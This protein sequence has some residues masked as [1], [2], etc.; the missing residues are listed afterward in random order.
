MK[1][2][3]LLA[4]RID[5]AVDPVVDQMFDLL[6]W[7]K[8][9]LGALVGRDKGPDEGPDFQ[10]VSSERLADKTALSL[11]AT[12][13][14]L[15]EADVYRL[16]KS[17]PKGAKANLGDVVALQIE[18]LVPLPAADAHFEA[19]IRGGGGQASEIDVDILVVESGFLD[20]LIERVV[21]EAPGVETICAE[22]AEG[23]GDL[24]ILWRSSK[25]LKR[26]KARCA[27][28]FF[29]TLAVVLSWMA[30]GA[31]QDRW[32][33]A[34]IAWGEAAKHEQMKAAE[35]RVL[36]QE[37]GVLEDR[38]E[39]AS[40]LKN[41]ADARHLLA[42]LSER[43]PDIAHAT[44]LEFIGHKFELTGH[45]AD[46]QA[47]MHAF[48]SDPRFTGLVF[49]LPGAPDKFQFVLTGALAP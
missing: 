48:E 47:V 21:R 4:A 15:D 35:V 26:R 27:S 12:T 42:F 36:E 49:D 24:V 46:P 28:A 29:C 16:C 37:L 11:T 23:N 30:S 3:A 41:A 6:V 44:R 34:E 9:E 32:A 33:K 2:P 17:F 19:T 10:T 25:L 40:G 13:V 8:S 7:W 39:K 43:L 14:R 45:S 20:D 38:L 5:N 31:V 1:M 18:H 22:G